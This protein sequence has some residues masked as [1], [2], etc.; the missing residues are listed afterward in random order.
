MA[1]KM[2]TGA[3]AKWVKEVKAEL[4]AVNKTLSDVTAACKGDPRDDVII[5][6]VMK[7]GDVL[8]ETWSVATKAYDNA[9]KSVEEGIDV[10]L[11]AGHGAI[12]MFDD[13]IA[14]HK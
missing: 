9:W 10:V 13:F 12:E 6:M 3:A 1:T 7:T 2:E 5:K 11:K 14:K 4:S 8:N